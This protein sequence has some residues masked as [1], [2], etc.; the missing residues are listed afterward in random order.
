MHLRSMASPPNRAPLVLLLV[1]A[2][3]LGARFVRERGSSSALDSPSL[4][5]LDS[6]LTRV[7]A[8]GKRSTKRSSRVTTA[9]VKGATSV[10]ST[11]KRRSGARAGDGPETGAGE[12]RSERTP[13][14]ALPAEILEER[15]RD[16]VR[17]AQTPSIRAPRGGAT[18]GRGEP[19]PAR[20][21]QGA[22]PSR[23][24][25]LDLETASVEELERLPR[26]G[27]ALAQRIVEDRQAHGPFGS[28][29]GL[30][31][32]R[33]IGPAMANLLRGR[34]TFNDARRP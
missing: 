27:P 17:T 21:P 6:Q 24:T 28:L 10:A 19:A 14:G 33:G 7:Q 16:S 18:G 20:A 34:V 12:V 30:Q 13:F 8:A 11:S 9:R 31:R 29:T 1:M 23:S 5:A 26:I 22:V 3:G 4:A 25:P 15:S 2:V 32:V